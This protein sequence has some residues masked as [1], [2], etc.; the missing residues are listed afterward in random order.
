MNSFCLRQVNNLAVNQSICLAAV[1]PSLVNA[2]F[3]RH[4]NRL[5][6]LDE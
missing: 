6:N 4:P 2:L 3:A 1:R 5:E